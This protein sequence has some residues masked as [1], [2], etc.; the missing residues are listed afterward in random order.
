MK[1]KPRKTKLPR[2]V[3]RVLRF[4]VP[5][6]LPPWF[7]NAFAAAIVRAR[8]CP[9]LAAKGLAAKAEEAIFREFKRQAEEYQKQMDWFREEKFVVLL[10]HYGIPEDAPGRWYSADAG[11]RFAGVLAQEL[12]PWIGTDDAPPKPVGRQRKTADKKLV[13]QVEA[14][15]AKHGGD[16]GEAFKAVARMRI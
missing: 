5:A 3:E 16:Y 2:R 6:S 13:M 8:A 11:W 15:L 12:F 10:K 9:E 4:H 14:A 7:F 1:K